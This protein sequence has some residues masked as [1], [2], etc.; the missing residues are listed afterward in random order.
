LKKSRWAATKK[1]MISVPVAPETVLNT[2]QQ[3]PRVPKEAGLVQVKLKRKKIYER[4]HKIELIDPEKIFRV[5]GHLKKSG[6]PYYQF[7]DDFKSYE[8]RCREQDKQ[9]H[10]LLFGEESSQEDEDIENIDGNDGDEDIDSADD[11]EKDYITKDTIRKH[12][13]DHNRNTCLTNNYPETFVDENGRTVTNQE[14]FSFAP[15]EGSYPTNL[16]EE[17]DWDIKSWPALHPDGRY[18][19]HHKRKVRLT[20]QQYFGQRILNKDQRFSKSPGYIFAAA[21]Y[22]EKKQLMSKA[23]ISF[24]RGRKSINKEGTTQYD[25]DDAFTTFDGVWQKV[26]YDMIAK[27]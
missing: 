4:S 6:H 20:E 15:A 18:G 27:L 11:V 19:L 23:N 17:K 14:E 22:T 26:K 3:L 12:Q 13:F 21:A 9:G 1:Q 16:L 24:M 10:Q 25:L 2:V 5:L 7:Y 8:K